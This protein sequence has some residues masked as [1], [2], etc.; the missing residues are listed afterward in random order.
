MPLTPS[1]FSEALLLPDPRRC[2]SSD[3]VD[4]VDNL[5]VDDVKRLR[6]GGLSGDELY[7]HGT[8][9]FVALAQCLDQ[10]S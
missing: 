8:K 6:A 4:F 1:P 9:L 5:E 3:I 2:V 10:L 7:I